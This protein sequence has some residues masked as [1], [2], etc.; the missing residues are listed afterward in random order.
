M[1][2]KASRLRKTA[3]VNFVPR[4]QVFPLSLTVRLRLHE[5][6]KIHASSINKNCLELF[7]CLFLILI[8]SQFLLAV[9]RKRDV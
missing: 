6:L 1:E 9:C 4:D 2:S 3:N 8:I 7:F 5:N